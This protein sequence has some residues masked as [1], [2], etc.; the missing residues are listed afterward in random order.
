MCH[1]CN[2]VHGKSSVTPCPI[3]QVFRSLF[4][5][6]TAYLFLKIPNIRKEAPWIN[7]IGLCCHIKSDR[8]PN[9]KFNCYSCLKLLNNSCVLDVYVLIGIY[10]RSSESV[11]LKNGHLGDEFLN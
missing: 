10:I 4:S 2:A 1:V 6:S 11:T 9:L 7:S 5:F 3:G 8:L